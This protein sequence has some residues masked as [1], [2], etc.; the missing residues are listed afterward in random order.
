[1]YHRTEDYKNIPDQQRWIL[2]LL[3][4]YVTNKL[5]E[6]YSPNVK[7]SPITIGSLCSDK[8]RTN[9]VW[10][11][12]NSK[13]LIKGYT[14]ALD[15]VPE[16]I[17]KLL[18][19]VSIK[20]PE[21]NT[22]GYIETGSC[23]YDKKEVPI[24]DLGV[25]YLN[26]EELSAYEVIHVYLHQDLYD[27][28][29]FKNTHHYEKSTFYGS[30]GQYVSYKTKVFPLAAITPSSEASI[31][32]AGETYAKG[33]ARNILTAAFGIKF[34]AIDNEKDYLSDGIISERLEAV[35]SKLRL[36]RRARKELLVLQAKTTTLGDAALKDTVVKTGIKYIRRKAPI[37]INSK[38]REEKALSM[39]VLKGLNVQTE[40]E[41][42]R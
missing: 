24:S 8:R 36:L 6:R 15:L 9:T 20:E 37:W 5:H 18:L 11:L 23:S 19:G 33:H 17:E 13:N 34:R 28:R 38:D 41:S 4:E 1:M 7:L 32:A 42:R 3:K 10:K 31:I 40:T 26:I 25:V 30:S 12:L 2:Y 35:E 16:E 27:I 14:T 39:L 29:E 21:F 22:S